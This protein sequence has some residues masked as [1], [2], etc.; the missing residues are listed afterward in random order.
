MI[1]MFNHQ[2]KC[3]GKKQQ[4]C[5]GPRREGEPGAEGDS[6]ASRRAVLPNRSPT[7][8]KGTEQSR[9]ADSN[10]GHLTLQ[11]AQQVCSD[12]VQDEARKSGQQG[13][14]RIDLRHRRTCSV[15]HVGTKGERLSPA[16]APER[17]L[18]ALSRIVLSWLSDPRL[19]SGP[20]VSTG[21]QAP[22]GR[23]QS[24]L[25]HS[26]PCHVHLYEK[27]QLLMPQLT[28]FQHLHPLFY[29]FF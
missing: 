17:L 9:S 22:A 25:V 14:V 19:M 13:W 6:R 24:V 4:E 5:A 28:E 27:S 18:S 26:G 10:R 2:A 11:T 29:I 23:L 21:S 20:A 16:G 15:A 3:T 1:H 7:V 12:D 8:P